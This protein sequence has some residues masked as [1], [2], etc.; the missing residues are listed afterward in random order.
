MVW[1][2]P[3]AR[4]LTCAIEPN[5]S[6]AFLLWVDT[7]H[8]GGGSGGE[9]LPKWVETVPT[10]SPLEADLLAGKPVDRLDRQSL[11]QGAQAQLVSSR[12]LESK[13]EVRSPRAFTATLDNFYFPGWSVHIDDIPVSISPAPSTSLTLARIPAGQH[14]VTLR[15]DSTREQV[16]SSTLSILAALV[17]LALLILPGQR[18]FVHTLQDS[19]PASDWVILAVIGAIA[20]VVRLGLAS[21]APPGPALPSA[22][23]SQ[24]ADLGGQVQLLGFQY[25]SPTVHAGDTLTV[26]LY[27]QTPHVLLT[28]YKSFV[29]VTD[30]NGK[31][32]TQ[33]DAVPANWSRPTTAWLPGEWV[34]DAHVVKLPANAHAPLDVWA[35]MYD[36][37]TMQ[38]LKPAGDESGRVKLS[39][40]TP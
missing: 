27:W 19:L 37:A 16:L 32:V 39:R 15:L 14:I 2:L 25:S 20:L 6:S 23:T 21:F 9:F 10:E 29:H 40:L 30:A 33:S 13:W 26:T 5:P 38:S 34:A 35:G 22:M 18:P 24:P 8:I 1:T 12:P 28:S 7:N 17:T 31:I 36:P 3:W 4:P 11:P